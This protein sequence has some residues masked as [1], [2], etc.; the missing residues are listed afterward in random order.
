MMQSIMETKLS[1][2]NTKNEILKAYEA[3]LKKVT[4]TSF[5]LVIVM[6]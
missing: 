4:E 6:I 5:M 1:D 3:L 2:K